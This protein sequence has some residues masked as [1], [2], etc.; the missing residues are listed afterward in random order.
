MTRVTGSFGASGDQQPRPQGIGAGDDQPL[1]GGDVP[2]PQ[3]AQC[4]TRKGCRQ[5]YWYAANGSL[6]RTCR[7]VTSTR[8]EVSSDIGPPSQFVFRSS[9]APTAMRTAW[10]TCTK[11]SDA[12]R[13]AHRRAT[14]SVWGS[15][16]VAKANGA[17]TVMRRRTT[18][19]PMYR[20][21]S[22]IASASLA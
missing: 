3:E 6:K 19:R 13:R 18:S 10:T 22:S 1:P 4:R 14:P 11:R 17:K 5:A 9:D 8:P 15:A 12:N 21:T 16:Y 7:R 2:D 20:T